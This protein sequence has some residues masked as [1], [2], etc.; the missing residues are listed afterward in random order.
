MRSLEAGYYELELQLFI[1][2]LESDR[3]LLS[4]KHDTVLG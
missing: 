4:F 1:Y 2:T 3:C